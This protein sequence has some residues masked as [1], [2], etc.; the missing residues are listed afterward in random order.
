[1]ILYIL[2]TQCIC[3]IGTILF[4][5]HFSRSNDFVD[6]CSLY[7]KTLH[8]WCKYL[9]KPRNLRTLFEEDG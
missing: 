6:I 5:S 4:L 7:R 1:M 9:R 2:S 8:F 3:S